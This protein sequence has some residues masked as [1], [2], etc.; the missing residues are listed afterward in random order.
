[1]SGNKIGLVGYNSR[2][3]FAFFSYDEHFVVIISKSATLLNKYSHRDRI[4]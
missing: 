3:I 4:H 1:M 2:N